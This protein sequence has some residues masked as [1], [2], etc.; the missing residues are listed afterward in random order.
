MNPE[1]ILNAV[2]SLYGYSIPYSPEIEQLI[3]SSKLVGYNAGWD[4]GL[5]TVPSHLRP[6][7][8]DAWETPQ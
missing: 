7:Y 8:E 1:Q 5:A 6:K 3:I 2:N 4:D